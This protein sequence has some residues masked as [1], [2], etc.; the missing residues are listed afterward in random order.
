MENKNVFNPF[1]NDS[2]DTPVDSERGLFDKLC[3]GWRG[4][5]Y[6]RNFH[7][8]AVT[9]MHGKAG[10]LDQEIQTRQ[11]LK[12]F[13]IV[14]NCGGRIHLR[15]LDNSSKFDAPAVIIGN[16]MSLLETAVMHAFLRPR[17]DFT[18]VIKRSLLDVPFFGNIMRALNA[19]PVDRVNPREDFK[20]VMEGGLK[21]LSAGQS[22]IVFPQST[23]SST[24]DPAEFNSIGVKLA[25]H[26]GV[27]IIPLD[28]RT[29]FLENGRKFRDLGPIRRENPVWFE[30][31]EPM[32]KVAGSGKAEQEAI[33]EFIKDR[34]KS[35]GG[36]VAESEIASPS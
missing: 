21:R 36:K 11:S 20:A 3:L 24:F 33:V 35:W 15:G 2:Y 4:S 5:F 28:L 9:G 12:N 23:R 14:E 34:L 10:T 18:F 25:K 17:R 13:R 30:F 7:V 27:P 26:A 22:V 32:M 8:F 1:P 19:I 29:D 31:G 6:L 16:H